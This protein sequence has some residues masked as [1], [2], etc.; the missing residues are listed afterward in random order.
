[1]RNIATSLWA[2]P[3]VTDPPDRGR[4]DVALVA[5]VLAGVAAEGSLRGDM[6]WRPAAMIFGC[7][8]AAAVPVRRTRPLGTVAFS[9]GTFAALDVFRFLTD[10]SPFYLY[11]GAIVLLFVYS[12][13]RWGA[14]RDAA[15]GLGFIT[16]GFTASVITDNTGP[17]DAVGGAAVLLFTAALGMSIRYRGTALTQLIEQ[18]KLHEREQL[19]R[20][21]HDTVAHHVSAIAIQAQAGLFLARSASLRGATDALEVIDREAAL[22]LAEMRSMVATLRDRDQQPSIA[23]QRSISDIERLV[24]SS[25]ETLRIEVALTGELADL[26]PTLE[27]AL[28]RVAQESVTNAQRHAHHASHVE[29]NIHG[30]ASEVQMTVSDDG[31]RS[32][33]PTSP[34]GYGLVGMTERVTLLGGTLTAGP[35]PGRGWSVRAVLPRDGATA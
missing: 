6:A 34:A 23:P 21:L 2:E 31:T 7:A 5:L 28:F 13:F 1:M 11:S 14:G 30:T 33:R 12:L 26:P 24:N 27:S 22:T 16:L 19:A 35:K 17:G 20:E 3:A 25:T 32:V 15:V 10:D 9:F 8:L 18:A 29:V 4:S